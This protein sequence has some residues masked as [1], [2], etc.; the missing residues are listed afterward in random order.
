VPSIATALNRALNKRVLVFASASNEGAN[1]PITFPARLHGIFCIGSADG[2]GASSSFN[3]PFIG[4]EKYSA[5]GEAVS[6]AC[7]KT[8]SHEPGYDPKHQTIR[9]DG[10]S[11]ATPIAA[12]IAALF[13]DYVRQF[14]EGD[15]AWSYDNMRKLFVRMSLATVEK[16][17]RYLAPWS[18]FGA[19][20]DPKTE[21][22]NILA[23][24]L[25]IRSPQQQRC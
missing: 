19:G 20:R 25:G 22:K 5:L 10:T 24:A 3:P 7:P 15:P 11:T 16:D 13:I 1:Y 12:G 14:L 18:L 17:Y 9:R 21:I 6:G 2:L 8:L 23:T 4:E